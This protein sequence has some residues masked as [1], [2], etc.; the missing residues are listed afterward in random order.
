MRHVMIDLETMS[1][2]PDAVILEI[3]AVPFSLEKDIVYHEEAFQRHVTIDSCL[4][5]GLHLSGGTVAWWLEQSEEA[6]RAIVIGQR[7]GIPIGE[8]LELLYRWFQLYDDL[9]GVWSH[10][11]TFDLPILDYA[12]KTIRG[13]SPPWPYSIT[14]D[15]RTAAWMAT[16]KYL[17]ADRGAGVHLALADAIF[18]AEA[19]IKTV[20]VGVPQ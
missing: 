16:N 3:A 5:A 17:R 6:R 1:T 19:M 14:R 20:G 8:A 13:S 10:G 11:A 2:R 4:D 18:Q 15:T 12:F 7:S 9:E